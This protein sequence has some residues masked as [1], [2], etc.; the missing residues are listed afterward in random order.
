MVYATGSC[1]SHV[2]SL[3]LNEMCLFLS[4]LYPSA[5]S[6]KTLKLFCDIKLSSFFL[7]EQRGP[8][9]KHC[10]VGDLGMIFYNSPT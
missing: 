9:Y 4:C 3:S 5:N 8:S 10:I 7:L 2:I 1:I 6:V